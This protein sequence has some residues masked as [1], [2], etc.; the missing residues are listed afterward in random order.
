MIKIKRCLVPS[1][2]SFFLLGPRGT[3]KTTWLKV[4]FP[5]AMFIDLLKASVFRKLQTDPEYLINIVKGNAQAKC[6]VI[7]EI[8][9]IPELLSVIHSLIEEHLGLQFIL[10]GSSAR[11]IKST[12]ADLLAG[13]A[14]Q[15]SMHPFLACELGDSFSL[16]DA[17]NYGMIPVIYSSKRKNAAISAYINLYLREEIQQEGLVR[18]LAPFSRFLEAVSF[19]H[20]SQLVSST[21]SRECGVGRT[22]VDNYLKILYDLMIA[23]TLPVFTK[24]AK[25]ALSSTSKFY[26]FDTGVYRA[27]RPKGP[28]D[29]PSEIDGM[30]LEGLVFQHLKSW[31]DYSE[32]YDSLYYWR[33]ANGNEVDFVIYDDKDFLA[34]EVKNTAKLDTKDFVGLKSFSRDYPE[35]RTILLYR[36]EDQYMNG[37]ILVMP[38]DRY[39]KN[40]IPGNVSPDAIWRR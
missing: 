8:Q 24:R 39:I 27:L 14:I 32:R 12:G 15:K 11:K 5:D 36:G 35:A 7:D 17:L 13:R 40:L 2:E 25:R 31:L 18:T 20:G 1:E 23:S 30:A 33:T 28:L 6:F 38:V 37:N 4:V 22:T 34:I 16:T 10:T 26:F 29:R 3:G 9:K 19:S 21:I